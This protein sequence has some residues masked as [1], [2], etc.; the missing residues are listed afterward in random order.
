[1]TL[2]LL[3]HGSVTGTLLCLRLQEPY[4]VPNHSSRRALV[5][6]VSEDKS[7]RKRGLVGPHVKT[8]PNRIIVL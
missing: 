1:M 3:W 2:K 8:T 4:Q 5:E 7:A 6:I